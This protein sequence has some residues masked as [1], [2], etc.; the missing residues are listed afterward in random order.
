[1]QFNLLLSKFSIIQKNNTPA[2]LTLK[3]LVNLIINR[4]S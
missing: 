3:Q 2:I 1:M 4:S